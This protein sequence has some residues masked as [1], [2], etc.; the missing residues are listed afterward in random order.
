MNIQPNSN[1]SVPGS[2]LIKVMSKL[3]EYADK[4]DTVDTVKK[5]L[6]EERELVKVLLRRLGESK[7]KL[8]TQQRK[9]EVE[10]YKKDCLIRELNKTINGLNTKI[11]IYC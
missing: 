10:L 11:D 7:S 2:D 5:H 3:Q 4:C 9:H 6:A 8:R 1:Y